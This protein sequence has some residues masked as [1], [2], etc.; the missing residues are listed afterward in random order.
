MRV[1]GNK[2]LVEKIQPKSQTDSGIF[3]PTKNQ[4][5]NEGIVLA[6]GDKAQFVKVGDKVRYYQNAGVYIEHEG[7]DCLFLKCNKENSEVE[8][9]L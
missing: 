6:I 1:L 5:N 3:I 9:I 2:I 7:K 8:I 4:K